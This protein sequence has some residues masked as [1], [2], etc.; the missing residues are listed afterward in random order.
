[1]SGQGKW[2][3]AIVISRGASFFA[4]CLWG[5][6]AIAVVQPIA[7]VAL[8]FGPPEYFAL[9]V[10]GIAFV[11]SLSGGSLAKGLIMATFG[12]WISTIGI[13]AVNGE[14]RYTFGLLQLQ[15][16]KIGRAHV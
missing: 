13:D 6:F 15:D 9:A 8:L 12:L 16:G 1:M 10:F 2:T 5:L 11:A 7:D 14:P 3:I 4:T